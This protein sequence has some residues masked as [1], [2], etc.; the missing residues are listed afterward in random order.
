MEKAKLKRLPLAKKDKLGPSSKF[1]PLDI[2]IFIILLIF[3]LLIIFPFY[4]LFIVSITPQEIYAKQNFLL[5]T[6]QP[7]FNELNGTWFP[8]RD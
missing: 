3:A 8:E 4:Y 2:V 6:N 7:T 5:W 1:G